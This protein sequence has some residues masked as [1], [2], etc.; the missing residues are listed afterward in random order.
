MWERPKQ[1]VS[2]MPVSL[3]EVP[4]TMCNKNI[5]RVWKHP[6]PTANAATVYARATRASSVEVHS[7]QLEATILCAQQLHV[8]MVRWSEQRMRLMLRDAPADLDLKA[9]AILK[10]VAS[11]RA[12]RP[13]RGP[14]VTPVLAQCQV[15]VQHR[16]VCAMMGI[17]VAETN[18]RLVVACTLSARLL[19]V[20]MAILVAWVHL[21]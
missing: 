12:L 14:V 10:Q 4:G 15:L 9:A 21:K 1:V 13:I 11:H 7:V 20:Q 6:V 3:E 19:L 8:I 17:L 5:L 18:C 16:C 2:A